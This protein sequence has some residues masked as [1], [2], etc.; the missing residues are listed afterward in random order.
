MSRVKE[1]EHLRILLHQKGSLPDYDTLTYI[2]SATFKPEKETT[3]FFK[4]FI[5]TMTTWNQ[6]LA[7]EYYNNN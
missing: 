7:L 4:G 5:S 1:K 3:A 2:T 6:D